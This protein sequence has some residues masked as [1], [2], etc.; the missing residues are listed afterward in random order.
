MSCKSLITLKNAISSIYARRNAKFGTAKQMKDRFELQIA[1]W[2]DSNCEIPQ[3][4][5]NRKAVKVQV[6]VN[7]HL[8]LKQ[9]LWGENIKK[10]LSLVS[11]TIMTYTNWWCVL[12]TQQCSRQIKIWKKALDELTKLEESPAKIYKDNGTS[13]KKK[14]SF[15]STGIYI[16]WLCNKSDLHPSAFRV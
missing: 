14:E 5:I 6:L 15:R 9:S 11:S 2:L 3:L 12:L 10:L 16:G 13:F 1:Q 8:N 4:N 7:V